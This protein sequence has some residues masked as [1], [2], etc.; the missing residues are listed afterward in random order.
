LIARI[1]SA[2]STPAQAPAYADHLRSRV[3]PELKK[4]DG[5]S[6]AML[7][8]RPDAGGVEIIVMTFWGSA[9]SIKAFAGTDLERA[10]VEEEAVPL[11]T[12]FDRRVRHY[13]IAVTDHPQS[14]GSVPETLPE[15]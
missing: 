14:A 5:Y 11:L 10:V 2:Q 1:W 15:K 8:E 13:D 3:L 7:L 9:D 4:M 12:R 6:G